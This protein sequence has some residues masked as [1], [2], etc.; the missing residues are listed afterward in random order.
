MLNPHFSY[1]SFLFDDLA[2]STIPT[3]TQII[4]R[5]IICFHLFL[6]ENCVLFGFSL[7]RSSDVLYNIINPNNITK[8]TENIPEIYPLIH[9]NILITPFYYRKRFRREKRKG[10]WKL[11]ILQKLFFRVF[12]TKANHKISVFILVSIYFCPGFIQIFNRL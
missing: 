10:A 4:P 7:I 12:V 2:I 3:I 5:N 6:F 1:Q 11:L 9:L 8:A